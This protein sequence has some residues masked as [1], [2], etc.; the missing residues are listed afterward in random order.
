MSLLKDVF[1]FVFL[2]AKRRVQCAHKKK[3]KNKTQVIAM[4]QIMRG[5][6]QGSV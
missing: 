4:T 6:M 2:N 1:F 5:Y 3:R